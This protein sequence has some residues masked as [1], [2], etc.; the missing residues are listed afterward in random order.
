MACPPNGEDVFSKFNGNGAIYKDNVKF[1]STVEPAID[2]TSASLL[3]FAWRAAGMPSDAIL[4][5]CPHRKT[6]I[7]TSCT[8]S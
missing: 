7:G 5:S 4:D 6:Q 1:Y 2:F 3:M 8:C